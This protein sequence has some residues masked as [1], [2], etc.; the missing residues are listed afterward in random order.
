MRCARLRGKQRLQLLTQP[1]A[2]AP[3]AAGDW[4]QGEARAAARPEE[5]GEEGEGGDEDEVY[6][7]FED[8]ETGGRAFGLF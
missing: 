7:D 6:G 2:C 4:D 1:C 3:P 5:E 8:L